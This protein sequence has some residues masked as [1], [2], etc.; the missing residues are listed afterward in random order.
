[1]NE[2]GLPGTA[3]SYLPSLLTDS[4][5]LVDRSTSISQALRPAEAVQHACL[6]FQ[7]GTTYEL[8]RDGWNAPVC[9]LFV[10]VA[11]GGV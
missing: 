3:I 10:V 5:D 8:G 4:P 6:G 9:G 7:L 11:F 2:F 1:M